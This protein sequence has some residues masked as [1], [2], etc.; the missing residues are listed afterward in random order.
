[1]PTPN[2]PRVRRDPAHPSD[3]KS[4][5]LLD[6]ELALHRRLGTTVLIIPYRHPLVT[7]RMV[8]NLAALSGGRFVFGVG[9]GWAK[10]EFAAL[11]IPHARRGAI[12]DDYLAAIRA[13][14]ASDL[15][16]HDGPFA[17]FSGVHTTPRSTP[18]RT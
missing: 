16:A 12:T 7:A 8:G 13:H 17:S 15:A 14:L 2:R 4:P 11:G 10:Q 1:M 18:C 3:A 9:S 6:L 5:H